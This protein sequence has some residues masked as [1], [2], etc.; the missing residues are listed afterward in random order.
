MQVHTVEDSLISFEYRDLEFDLVDIVRSMV[1][2]MDLESKDQK[3]DF[4]MV[5]KVT[6][7]MN[8]FSKRVKNRGIFKVIVNFT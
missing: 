8:C 1:V 3:M 4:S 5:K 6:L 7:H 2:E